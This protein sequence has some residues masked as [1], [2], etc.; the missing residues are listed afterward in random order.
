MRLIAT[1][2]LRY[3]TRMLKAGDEFD[4]DARSGRIFKAIRKAKDAPEPEPVVEED[5]LTVLRREYTEVMGKRPG[6]MWDADTLRE[7]MSDRDED[8]AGE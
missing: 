3:G 6:P 8:D 4:A 5:E 2:P 7:K 1:K